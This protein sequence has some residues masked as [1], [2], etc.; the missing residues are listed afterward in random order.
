VGVVT[1]ITSKQ[2]RDLRYES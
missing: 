2:A 1:N